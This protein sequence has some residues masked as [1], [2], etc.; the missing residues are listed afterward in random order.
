MGSIRNGARSFLNILHKACQLSHLP[1]FRS[2][3]TAILGSTD[4]DAIYIL[5]TPLCQVVE[6]L[7]A[8]DNFFNQI[9]YQPDHTGDEDLDG[10]I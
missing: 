6:G 3:L 5:W 7:V 10:G 4:A 2:G 1:G 9:D 8:A